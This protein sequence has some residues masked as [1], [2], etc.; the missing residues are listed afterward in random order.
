MQRLYDQKWLEDESHVFLP[1]G[2][3]PRQDPWCLWRSQ[4]ILP[5]RC[6]RPLASL[7]IMALSVITSVVISVM[8]IIMTTTTTRCQ[9]TPLTLC[10]TCPLWVQHRHYL[11]APGNPRQGISNYYFPFISSGFSERNWLEKVTLPFLYFRRGSFLSMLP[12]LSSGTMN[13]YSSRWIWSK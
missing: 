12:E 10:S 9:A 7:T 2:S 5:L 11:R 4:K 6:L 8:T 13:N 3:F 1:G